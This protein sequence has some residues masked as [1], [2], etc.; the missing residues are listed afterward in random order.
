MWE[1]TKMNY[2]IPGTQHVSH[3]VADLDH[4]QQQ[5]VGGLLPCA[6]ESLE[7]CFNRGGDRTADAPGRRHF[8]LRTPGGSSVGTD[9]HRTG[10]PVGYPLRYEGL[11]C[12]LPSMPGKSWSVGSG[13]L[14]RSRRS[15][16]HL[17]RVP[18]TQLSLP[19]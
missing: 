19:P 1:R 7:H 3:A 5:P 4:T 2:A 17:R 15:V 13:W 12:T 11:A 9:G 8:G 10:G 16:P 14:P 6:V 18:W